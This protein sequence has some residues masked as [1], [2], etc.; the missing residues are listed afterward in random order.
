VARPNRAT[1]E[2]SGCLPTTSPFTPIRD[3]TPCTKRRRAGESAR[4]G[5]L[6]SR[7]GI[8][9]TS[10]T[11]WLAEVPARRTGT[12]FLNVNVDFTRPSARRRHYRPRVGRSSIQDRQAVTA[13]HRPPLV[14]TT[15]PRSLDGHRGLLT[16]MMRTTGIPQD[17]GPHSPSLPKLSRGR[18]PPAGS[19][20]AGFGV[21]SRATPQNVVLRS[22]G[23]WAVPLCPCLHTLRFGEGSRLW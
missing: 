15:G 21:R 9:A 13:A 20:P 4:F 10:S 18:R 6:A 3:R 7:R 12:V 11:R 2:L 19:N 16:T 22:R 1:A 14:R 5:E 23:W 17:A 8:T